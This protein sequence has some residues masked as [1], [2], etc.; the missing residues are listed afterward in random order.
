MKNGKADPRAIMTAEKTLQAT[1]V[2]C[3][4]L[5]GSRA[6]ADWTES[7]D[8]DLMLLCEERMELTRS[9]E[10][11][12]AASRICRE[13]FGSEI[14]VDVIPLTHREFREMGYHTIN[15]VAARARREGIIMPRDPEGFSSRYSS[16]EPDENL[17][18]TERERRIGDANMNYRSLQGLLDLG[19][20]DKNTAYMAQQALENAM[21]AM[22][23]AMGEEYNPHHQV[24]ALAADIRRIDR[25]Q[26]RDRTWDLASNLGQLENFA[27]ASRY[28]PVI[29]PIEDYQEMANNITL[30]LDL[31][32]E[33][34]NAITG[35]M[36][37]EIPPE[38]ETE[39]INPRWQTEP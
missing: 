12:R 39:P 25:R 24:R 30:D 3:V 34:I 36:P 17:E 18:Y 28:G 20:E 9:L 26:G 6:R 31:I 2:D 33:R 5:F 35:E 23:S 11:Q 32:Y 38:G 1:D 14:Q 27:G 22:I 8:L 21:K 7:S 4:I 13:T 15:H 10:M 19:L 16:E 37:W 29:S